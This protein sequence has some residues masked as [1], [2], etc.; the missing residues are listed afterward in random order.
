MNT[1]LNLLNSSYP[2]QH[3]S[4]IANH[5]MRQSYA[6]QGGCY[7]QNP[8]AKYAAEPPDI[9]IELT[10]V[11]K[12][13]HGDRLRKAI[14]QLQPSVPLA[15]CLLYFPRFRLRAY[16]SRKSLLLS[17]PVPKTNLTIAF[18]FLY[19]PSFLRGVASPQPRRAGPSNFWFDHSTACNKLCVVGVS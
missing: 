13:H 12:Y 6:H 17:L 5:W 3:H 9:S 15:D 1:L 16:L 2:T 4:L 14:P 18:S 19:F 7:L 8:K 10:I 11:S